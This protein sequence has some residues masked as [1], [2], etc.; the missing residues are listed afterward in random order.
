MQHAS[1]LQRWLSLTLAQKQ[2]L[3]ILA[4]TAPGFHLAEVARRHALPRTTLQGALAI[5]ERLHFVRQD[6]SGS[7]VVWRFEDPFMREWLL[8][9]QNA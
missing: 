5:L 7:T 4:E 3:K 8:R 6:Y 2:A 9:L 1:Y